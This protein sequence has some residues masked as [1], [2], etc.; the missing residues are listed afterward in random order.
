LIRYLLD[1][2]Y[3]YEEDHTDALCPIQ[4]ES[5]K[6]HAGEAALLRPLSTDEAR[7]MFEMHTVTTRVAVREATLSAI[8]NAGTVWTSYGNSTLAPFPSPA[9]FPFPHACANPP[10]S[11]SVWPSSSMQYSVMPPIHFDPSPFPTSNP[12]LLM[13]RRGIL[14]PLPHFQQ[15]ANISP[16]THSDSPSRPAPVPSR[17]IPKVNDWKQVV[18]D[19]EHAD[20]SRSLSVALRDWPPE[21]Y[22]RS[23]SASATL[24]SLRNQRKTI[25]LEFI[26]RYNRDEANFTAAYPMHSEG[27]TALRQAILKA[28]QDSGKVSTRRSK[29]RK[30]T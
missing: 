7:R 21:W 6:S 16:I 22:S 13:D 3:S 10:A 30:A 15:A 2:L 17:V 26:D 19:W 20:P 8:S 24:G 12:C 5:D 28:N 18:Q 14:A 11:P 23:E 4:L 27:I 29:K 1:E 9:P 25:A